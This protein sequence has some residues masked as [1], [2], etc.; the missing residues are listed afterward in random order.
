MAKIVELL[1][2]RAN[3]WEQAKGIHDK[4]VEEQ[5]SLTGEEQQEYDRIT[6]EMDGLTE[7]INREK[8]MEE[9]RAQMEQA[10]FEK[11][12]QAT[13]N[14]ER[15][16]QAPL[17]TEEYREAFNGWLK[18]GAQELSEE[19][20]S[21]LNAG[22]QTLETRALSAVTGAAGGFTVPQGFY[23]QIIQ[24]MKPFGGMRQ[25]RATVLRTAA[26]NDLPIPMNDDTSNMGAIVGENAAAGNAT[27]PVFA[28]KILKAYKYTSK[29]FLIPIEL[30]QDSA[31]DV[32]AYIR[33]K[34]TERIGRI[35]NLHFTTGTGSSQ[36]RGVVTDAVL[37]K[38]GATGQTTSITYDDLVDLQHSVNPLYRTN[39][40]WMFNDNTL[41]AIRKLKDST[42]APLWQPG[43]VASEPDKILGKPYII[44]TDMADMAANAKSI[45]F[46]DFANYFIRDVMDLMIVRISE[47]YIE[48]G[49][50]GFVAFSRQDGF[51][52]DAGQGPIKYYANSA[53]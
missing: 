13:N 47:K 1:Q 39:G 31:F 9:Q 48:S 16:E 36:P 30:L 21:I 46:G 20:R 42:G 22:R 11:R 27:D 34:I 52:V 43:L 29:T 44:N 25:S 41:K 33:Q 26:G 18:F 53:T 7:T 10:A 35:L 23:N 49:Q 15:R 38:T 6:K 45:L 50:I 12:E 14:S 4:S 28:Q 3:L 2:K 40:E 51:L 37:G 17:D 24:A 19:Q 8:R 32:E 5:R